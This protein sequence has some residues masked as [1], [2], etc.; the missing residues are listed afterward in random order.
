MRKVIQLTDSYLD[1]VNKIIALCNDGSIWEYA[2]T[3]RAN[4]YEWVQI[5]DIPQ[6]NK[7]EPKLDSLDEAY[8]KRFREN[9]FKPKEPFETNHLNQFPK[10]M[11]G[12][13]NLGQAM[14][15]NGLENTGTFE[16]PKDAIHIRCGMKGKSISKTFKIDP[17]C[18]AY[19]QIWQSFRDWIS[20]ADF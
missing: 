10:G 13:G 12:D 20:D 5:P 11:A 17:N 2:E 7:I 15:G 16:I 1:S 14:G 9:L 19:P 18:L 4:G 6:P 3:D 8:H